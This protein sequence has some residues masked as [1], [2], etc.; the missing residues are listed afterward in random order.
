M[1]KVK[2]TENYTGFTISG[3]YEDLD[4]LY[5]SI[6]YFIKEEP[7]NSEEEILQ[8]HLYA[9]LYD[10]RHAYQGDREYELID[11]NLQENKR[12]WFGI[13]KKDITQNNIYYSFNYVITD[14]ILDMIIIKYFIRKTD[15]KNKNNNNTYN[16]YLNMT[17]Y[18]YSIVLNSL[19]KIL[20]QAK[21]NKLKKGILNAYINEKIYIYQWFEFVSVKYIKMTKQQKEKEFMK[22]MKLVYD[23]IEYQD[24]YDMKKALEK[25]ATKNNCKTEDLTYVEYPEEIEW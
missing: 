14:I 5:E 21:F 15:K 7:K 18:F 23:Y 19:T 4:T 8:N 6:H 2:I 1:L 16:E 20:T 10:V 9:F 22:I 25:S 3:D 12:E 17:N 13:R 11:N 24:Y